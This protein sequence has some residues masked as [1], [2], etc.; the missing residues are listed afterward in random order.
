ME[1]PGLKVLQAYLQDPA[2]EDRMAV[3]WHLDWAGCEACEA[4]LELLL[5][6]EQREEV[7]GEWHTL[8]LD[9]AVEGPIAIGDVRHRIHIAEQLGTLPVILTVDE[10]DWHLVVRLTTTEPGLAG[11]EIDLRLAGERFETRCE[12]TLVRVSEQEWCATL[13]IPSSEERLQDLSGKC[14]ISFR[15]CEELNES[16]SKPLGIRDSE[17]GL[18][19]IRASSVANSSKLIVLRSGKKPSMLETH[20]L[21]VAAHAR[22]EPGWPIE[23]EINV[24]SGGAPVQLRFQLTA[25]N[26]AVELA[27]TKEERVVRLT[28]RNIP[29]DVCHVIGRRQLL[30]REALFKLHSQSTKAEIEQALLAAGLEVDVE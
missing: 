26:I 9:T 17:E 2:Y 22:T 1:C 25:R 11:K 27:D 12:L 23:V 19:P 29:I 18:V 21:A 8:F 30:A 3:E 10:K 4:R 7:A 6:T 15:I 16:H 24:A 5:A 28:A 14:L 13:T 20:T